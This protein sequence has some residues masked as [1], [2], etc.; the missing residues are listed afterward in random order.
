MAQVKQLIELGDAPKEILG[1]L[2]EE[3]DQRNFAR[4]S[5][6]AEMFPKSAG[7]DPP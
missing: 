4:S 5:R 3:D 2:S 6:L 7:W 1:K